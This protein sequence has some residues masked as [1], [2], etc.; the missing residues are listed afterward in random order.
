VENAGTKNG[1]F[2]GEIFLF[3]SNQ[4]YLVKHVW[5]TSFYLVITKF[6]KSKK[7]RLST[8]LFWTIW[9][10]QLQD[11]IKEGTKLKDLKIQGVL[12]HGKGLRGIK[13]PR[14]KKSKP[15]VVATKT[16]V[17]GFGYMSIWFF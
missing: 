17:S 8:F 2:R 7:T 3:V 11:K 9:F 12:R 15:K 13:E 4:M 10:W 1:R 16:G 14:W 6:D 5:C